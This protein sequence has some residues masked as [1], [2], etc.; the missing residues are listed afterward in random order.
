MHHHQIYN[1]IH[2][3]RYMKMRFT[4]THGKINLLRAETNLVPPMRC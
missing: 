1:R 3:S 4:L 2:F